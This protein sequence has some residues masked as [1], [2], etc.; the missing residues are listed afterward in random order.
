MSDKPK[1]LSDIDSFWDLNSL[2]PKKRPVTP[3][4]RRTNTDTVELTLNSASSQHSGVSVPPRVC[5]PASEKNKQEGVFDTAYAREHRSKPLDPYLI[6]EPSGRLLRRVEVSKWESHFNF[7]ESFRTDARRLWERKGTPCPPVSYFSYIPQYSQLKY[8]QLKWYLWWRTNIYSGVYLQCDFCYILLFIY[9][10][11][12]CPD[13]ISPEKGLELLCNIWL[14][15]RDEHRRID[16]Y[17]CDWLCDYCLIH[18]LPCPSARLEPILGII[19]ET[20][21][22]K[23]FYM[24]GSNQ[25]D[26]GASIMFYTS[27]YDWHKSRY[28]TNENISVF[29]AHI[30]GAFNEAYRLLTDSADEFAK[31]FRTERIA[32]EGALCSYDMKRTVAVEYISYTR[33]QKLRFVV[34]DI[35]KYSENRIR[36]ALGIKSRLKVES[37]P[38][39]IRTAIDRYFDAHL[40]A[41][42]KTRTR[43]AA[44]LE[45]EVKE[46]DKLYEPVSTELS[47]ENALKIE[48]RSWS[49]TEILISAFDSTVSEETEAPP[50]PTAVSEA[51]PARKTDADAEQSSYGDDDEFAALISLL[52]TSARLALTLLSNGDSSG[53]AKAAESAKILPEALVDRINETAFDVIGDSIIEPDTVGFKLISD[54]EGDIVKWLK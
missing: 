21:S 39:N 25:G 2:L 49:T 19:V 22:L 31:E 29:S 45:Y 7:Y 48:K 46:Y 9:E 52:D 8:S 32:Y 27:L 44:S 4:P 11:I 36:M 30:H 47:L 51:I 42:K 18:R 28:V 10:I 5:A 35:I 54:Y 23:E 15:Y 26:A 43:T 34:T 12:N 40:P 13:L 20:A 16:I 24:D 1:T 3:Y 37:L 53:I 38:D 14:N 6:Y 50:E 33:S 17:L 41:P